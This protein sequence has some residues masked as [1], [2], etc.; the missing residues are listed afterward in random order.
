MIYEIKKTYEVEEITCGKVREMLRRAEN[1]H[2]LHEFIDP[3]YPDD[4]SLFKDSWDW[5]IARNPKK[6]ILLIVDE[7]SSEGG[8]VKCEK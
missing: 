6:K 5:I 3:N 8:L 2:W 7:I 4:V 1:V